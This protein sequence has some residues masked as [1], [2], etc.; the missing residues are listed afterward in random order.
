MESIRTPFLDDDQVPEG[1]APIRVEIVEA[2]GRIVFETVWLERD[3]AGPARGRPLL[4][5]T[6]RPGPDGL[7]L[8]QDQSDHGK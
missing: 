3:R 7:G 8:V 5:A 6:A 1:F 2:D 4:A